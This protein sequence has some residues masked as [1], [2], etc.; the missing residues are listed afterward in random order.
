MPNENKGDVVIPGQDPNTTNNGTNGEAAKPVETTTPPAEATKDPVAPKSLAEIVSDGDDDKGGKPNN[1]APDGDKPAKKSVFQD[2]MEVKREN[3]EM[4]DL[5]TEVVP[6]I[7]NLQ[8]QVKNGGISNA[9]AKDEFDELATKY[10]LKPEFVKDLAKTIENK[11]ASTIEKKYLTEIKDIKDKDDKRSAETQLARIT[12]AVDTEINRVLK[13]SPQFAKIANPEAIKKYVLADKTNLQKSMDDIVEE[14]YGNA[15]KD[16]PS[17]DGYKAGAAH[18]PTAPDYS[19]LDDAGHEKVAEAR[20]NGGKEFED[21]QTDLLNRLQ[22][23]TRSR[24]ATN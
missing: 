1:Q 21:Y 7:K 20:R 11:A 12:H 3:K 10:E 17:M 24:H 9:D 23:R 15:V 6:L 19:N 22:N 16:A 8:E 14:L 5:L 2:L 18:T 13:E 4:K